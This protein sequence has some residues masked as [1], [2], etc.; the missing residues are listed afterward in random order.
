MGLSANPRGDAGRAVA[1]VAAIGAIC[2]AGV[3]VLSGQ[4]LRDLVP[5]ILVLTAV[6]APAAMMA[7]RLV[8]AREDCGHG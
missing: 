8:C 5:G 6:G 7:G 1:T 4:S 3:P 2:L